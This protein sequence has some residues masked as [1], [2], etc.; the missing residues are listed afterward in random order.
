M[1]VTTHISNVTGTIFPV[2]DI[3]AVARE[4]GLLYLVDGAQSAGTLPLDLPRCPSISTH[5][6]VTKASSDPPARAGF[7]SASGSI[8]RASRRSGRGAR[9]SGRRRTSRR[10][11]FPTDSS[12]GRPT[13]WASRVWGRGWNSWRRVGCGQGAGAGNRPDGAPGRWTLRIPG[14]TVYGPKTSATGG[15]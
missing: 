1:I 7:T 12:A 6:R 9:G 5:S 2:G 8:S 13:R 15:P 14:L 10:R 4:R 11:S 3:G